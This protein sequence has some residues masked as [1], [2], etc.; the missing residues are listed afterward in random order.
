MTFYAMAT[1]LTPTDDSERYERWLS[2]LDRRDPRTV[3][4]QYLRDV[5]V[6]G[7]RVLELLDTPDRIAVVR[8][9]ALNDHDWLS[10][11]YCAEVHV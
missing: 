10:D 1:K 3:A 2:R 8:R 4:E 11:R 5:E 7:A 9:W 6:P